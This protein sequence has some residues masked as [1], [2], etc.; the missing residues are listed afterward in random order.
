MGTNHNVSDTLLSSSAQY[1]R[2]NSIHGQLESELK[3]I[4]RHI[5]RDEPSLKSLKFRKLQVA[6]Q[7]SLLEHMQAS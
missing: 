1:R 5:C 3:E 6:D 2:L 7:M 4:S